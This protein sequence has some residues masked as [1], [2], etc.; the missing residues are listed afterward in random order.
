MIVYNDKQRLDTRFAHL[1]YSQPVSVFHLSHSFLP[2]FLICLPL[3]ASI[4]YCFFLS[5][6]SVTVSDHPF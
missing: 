6:D 2:F 3:V 5:V 4:D 1:F